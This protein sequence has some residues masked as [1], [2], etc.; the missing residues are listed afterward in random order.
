MQDQ[1]GYPWAKDFNHASEVG[2]LIYLNGHSQTNIDF[3][4][5]QCAQHQFCPKD[6]HYK[7]KRE[8]VAT[9]RRLYIRE[10]YCDQRHNWRL[11]STQMQNFL[12]SGG[13]K[14]H[15]NQIVTG[16]VQG[17]L[18]QHMIMG[19]TSIFTLFLRALF[20][21]VPQNGHATFYPIFELFL[22]LKSL[23]MDSSKIEVTLTQ[24]DP[25]HQI[26]KDLGLK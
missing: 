23:V 1:D 9:R 12:V 25:T 5:H 14:L 21:W 13:M 11:T 20:L 8:L 17:V 19:F 3:S 22:F 6:I 2:M 26:V 15:R 18:W 16:T 7:V 10:C 4:V 24:T